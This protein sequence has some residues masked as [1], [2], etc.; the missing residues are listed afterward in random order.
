MMLIPDWYPAFTH[1]DTNTVHSTQNMR[2]RHSLSQMLRLGDK[3]S[4]DIIVKV[5]SWKEY[6]YPTHMVVLNIWAGEY[7]QG[8]LT[9]IPCW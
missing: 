5:Y 1:K 2:K 3:K 7:I 6:M 8:V 4:K 9:S